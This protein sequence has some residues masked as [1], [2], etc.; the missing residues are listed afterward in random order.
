MG[1]KEV[2]VFGNAL[3]G[4]VGFT[5]DELH[6]I[7]CAVGQP[8]AEVALG[9]PAPPSDLEHL[10]EIKL[11]DGEEDDKGPQAR[12][13]GSAAWRKTVWFLSCRAVKKVLFH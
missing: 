6:S 5:R 7:V 10:V 12:R 9:K 3:V 2:H 13:R 11:V 8:R 1:N 4:I